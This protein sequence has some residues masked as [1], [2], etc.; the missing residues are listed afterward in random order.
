MATKTKKRTIEIPKLMSL[1][2]VG[3]MLKNL[4]NASPISKIVAQVTL[5][6]LINGYDSK[7]IDSATG[8]PKHTPG[9]KDFFSEITD[10]IVNTSYEDIKAGL[11]AEGKLCA[12]EE[13]VIK[14]GDDIAV[15]LGTHTGSIFEIDSD[16]KDILPDR[17]KK[18][19][20]VINKEQIKEDYEKDLLPTAMRSYCSSHK[21]TVTKM[22]QR[23]LK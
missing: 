15:S 17:Y 13:P 14:I 7:E 3:A 1:S 21:V 5:G 23:K 18:Q 8:K 12:G 4:E 6:R 2:E 11:I 20:I 9:L 16:I 19:I 10:E 22:T